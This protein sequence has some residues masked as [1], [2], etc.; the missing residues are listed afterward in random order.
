MKN[1]PLV[2]IFFL[3]HNYEKLLEKTVSSIIGQSYPNLEIIISDNQS[4]DKTWDVI[5]RIQSQNPKIISRKNIP[6]LKTDEFFDISIKDTPNTKKIKVYDIC[7]NHCNGCLNS[8]LA[9]G[10][11]IIFCHQDDIYEKDIIKKEAEFLMQNPDIPAVFTLGNIIDENNRIVGEFK[12]PQE[13]KGKKIYHFIEIFKAILRHGDMFL[14]TP[15]FMAR[16][17]IFDKVGLFD[18]QG[19]FGG[20]DDLEMWLRILEKYP[21]GILPENLINWRNGGRGKKYNQLRTE[22]ADFFNVMDYYLED[23]LY[24]DKMDKKSLRQYEYQKHFDNTLRAMNFLIKNEIEETKKLI[25]KP[26]SFDIFLAF[27]E[28]INIRRIKVAILRIIIFISVNLGLS[29]PL[30]KFLYYLISI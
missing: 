14:I 25:N 8:K 24:L 4:T 17:E 30:G 9:K 28:N 7:L 6:N 1:N 20:A 21:I 29:R 3:T 15:T 12:L 22:K 18:D 2:T 19:P 5:K 26:I 13:L 23:K 27:F 16:K 11:F 10:E